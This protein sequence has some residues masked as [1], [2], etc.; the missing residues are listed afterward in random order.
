MFGQ[1]SPLTIWKCPCPT[2]K[3]A[4]LLSSP[5]RR[6]GVIPATPSIFPTLRKDKGDWI[7]I[8]K[9]S[10]GDWIPSDSANFITSSTCF[11]KDNWIQTTW[12]S[13]SWM[14]TGIFPKHRSDKSSV[15]QIPSVF[16]F[17]KINQAAVKILFFFL[18]LYHP[19]GHSN[20]SFRPFNNYPTNNFWFEI[21]NPNLISVNHNIGLH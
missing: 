18:L 19:Q 11:S 13:N 14:L 1:D 12:S 20:S 21:S 8:Q 16:G 10:K 2:P 9:N 3:V 4:S 17:Q 15:C 7:A 6:S 5:K